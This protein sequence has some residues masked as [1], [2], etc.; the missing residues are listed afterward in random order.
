MTRALRREVVLGEA[1]G[2]FAAAAL[3]AAAA[4]LGAWRRA[5]ARGPS[6]V[7]A[8]ERNS[9]RLAALGPLG[10]PRGTAAREAGVLSPGLGVVASR[11]MP[12]HRTLGLQELRGVN[13][14]A[15]V[16]S[17]ADAA[18][19]CAAMQWDSPG[20][21]ATEQEKQDGGASGCHQR[22]YAAKRLSVFV[23]AIYLKSPAMSSPIKQLIPIATDQ[24]SAP[25]SRSSS[26]SA[27]TAHSL[28]SPPTRAATAHPRNS[29]VFL[30]SSARAILTVSSSFPA[31]ALTLSGRPPCCCY[32]FSECPERPASVL[33]LPFLRVR[34]SG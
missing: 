32:H 33:L 2:R 31:V 24:K 1:R 5:R 22:F 13:V 28:L 18:E 20:S 12:R 19:A 26:A 14:S 17:V 23:L 10:G 16:L 25:A 15:A 34:A 3:R 29:A 7:V 21:V 27:L 9:R 4:A 6:V 11:L 8:A 30:P